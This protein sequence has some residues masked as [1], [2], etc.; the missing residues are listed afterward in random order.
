MIGMLT[1][2]MQKTQF[3]GCNWVKTP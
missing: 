3:T 1:V 2:K